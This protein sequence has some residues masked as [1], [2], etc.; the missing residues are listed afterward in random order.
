MVSAVVVS[1]V[2]PIR[3]TGTTAPAA[4]VLI[5]AALCTLE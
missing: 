2:S 5:R 1:R 4:P 3:G